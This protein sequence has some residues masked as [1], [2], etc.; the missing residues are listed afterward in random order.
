M[1][2]P[3]PGAC[4]LRSPIC[5]SPSKKKKGKDGCDNNYHGY[6]PSPVPSPPYPPRATARVVWALPY[7]AGDA[8][9]A[10]RVAEGLPVYGN[11]DIILDHLSRIPQLHTTLCTLRAVFYLV[12]RLAGY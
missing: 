12:T 7:V 6:Q 5:G 8:G 3:R 11:F 9:A 10:H 4:T 1:L 2:G